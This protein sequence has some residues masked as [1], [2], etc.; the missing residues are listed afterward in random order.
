MSQNR[1]ALQWVTGPASCCWSA[2]SGWKALAH[3]LDNIISHEPTG[4]TR[5]I[6]NFG[7]GAGRT[8]RGALPDDVRS[9]VTIELD[10]SKGTDG[11]VVADAVISAARSIA[12]AT[13]KEIEGKIAKLRGPPAP[14]RLSDLS[15]FHTGGQTA[16]LG[17]MQTKTGIFLI[18]ILEHVLLAFSQ[19][20]ND[21]AAL[22]SYV[23]Q[24][25][26]RL[27]ASYRANEEPGLKPICVLLLMAICRSAHPVWPFGPGPWSCG[28]PHC[29]HV[30]CNM[31]TPA[32]SRSNQSFAAFGGGLLMRDFFA[33]TLK[34]T[35]SLD[36]LLRSVASQP[37]G[38]KWLDGAA[39]L[40]LKKAEGIRNAL[41]SVNSFDHFYALH[42]EIAVMSFAAGTAYQTLAQFG[43]D[44]GSEFQLLENA[45]EEIKA[46]SISALVADFD[47]S[48]DV[49]HFLSYRRTLEEIQR[50]NGVEAAERVL[51]KWLHDETLLPAEFERFLSGATNV[52][53]LTSPFPDKEQAQGCATLF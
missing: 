9:L 46:R 44:R 14:V 6:T 27:Q 5:Y 22:A 12:A 26:E 32:A 23:N 19:H 10:L 24:Y 2:A 15:I 4:S 20:A 11:T 28:V 25:E 21:P 31:K 37:N 16:F 36:G 29:S 17:E 43:Q 47:N 39:D 1:A 18:E 48:V 30:L 34:N 49:E 52:L 53:K 7:S 42:H 3:G 51:Q 41:Q 45:S 50:E 13:G 35:I 33:S 38:L 40:L 8:W